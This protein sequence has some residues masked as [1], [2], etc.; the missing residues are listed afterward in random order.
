MNILQN[1]RRRDHVGNRWLVIFLGICVAIFCIVYLLYFLASFKRSLD[2][3]FHSVNTRNLH[4]LAAASTLKTTNHFL[5][6]IYLV[7][8]IAGVVLII[9]GIVLGIKRQRDQMA[10]DESIHYASLQ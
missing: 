5:K 10:R 7:V 9:G 3:F 4:N 6:P 8:G 1:S 2:N